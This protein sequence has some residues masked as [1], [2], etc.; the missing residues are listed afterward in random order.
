MDN[1]RDGSQSRQIGPR[2]IRAGGARDNPSLRSQCLSAHSGR[3]AGMASYASVWQRI[4]HLGVPSF[5]ALMVDRLSNR[6]E[7]SP[8]EA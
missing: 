2:L 6:R 4:L 8:Q 3:F 5:I 1:G 7:E